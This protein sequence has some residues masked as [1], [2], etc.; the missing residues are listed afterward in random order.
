MENIFLTIFNMS[1]TASY[2][3]LAVILIRLLLKKAPKALRVIM[4]ALVGIRLIFPFSFESILSLIPSTETVPQNIIYSQSPTINSGIPTINNAINPVI[5]ESLAPKNDG[6]NS[7]QIWVLIAAI[8]W[9]I[10]IAAMVIYAAVSYFKIRFKI[11]E[12]AH[13]KENIYICDNV[14][15]PFILGIIKPKI[16][17]PSDMSAADLEYVTAHEKAHIKRLDHLWK[18]L[19]FLL[20]SVYWFNP[21]LWVAYILLCKDIELACDE[22][23]IRQMGAEIKKPYS[24][25]LLNCSVPKRL[26]SACPL[27]FGETGVK[28]RIK[29]VL[30]YKRPTFW[31]IAI[32]LI[33]CIILSI[34]FLT[35]PKSTTI[36]YIE[37]SDFSRQIDD[38]VSVLK[39]TDGSSFSS[40]TKVDKNLLKQLF[41]IEI[42]KNAV[43][44]DRSDYFYRDHTN[45][46]VLRETGDLTPSLSSSLQGFYICFNKDFTEVFVCGR[47]FKTTLSYRVKSPEKAKQ[48]FNKFSTDIKYYDWKSYDE[49]LGLPTD[50]GLEVYVWM[51]N[52]GLYK[53]VLKSGRNLGYTDDEIFSSKPAPL[54]T[55]RTI[56]SSYDIPQDRITII[57]KIHPDYNLKITEE[58]V[59]VIKF[60]LFGLASYNNIEYDDWG[61]KM[62]LYLLD[63]DYFQVA[64][65][66]SPEH[67]KVVGK[68][69][70]S[71]AF[72]LRAIHNGKV[73]SFGDYMRNVLNQKDYED[74]VLAWDCV[75]YTL[76]SGEIFTLTD[77]FKLT[78]GDLPVGEYLLCKEVRFEDANGNFTIRTYTA[79][80]AVVD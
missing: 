26:I 54:A 64:F 67:Q 29:S 43:S 66:R 77:S 35:N 65:E 63:D 30:N 70:T 75:L 25:A 18:P 20:L 6:S 49:Y 76:P 56:L 48:I 34:C 4:W 72:E 36:T 19:G 11:R 12:A 60:D 73:I 5:S 50:K 27:A 8:V 79:P 33:S 15:T 80:F 40:I 38:T 14:G 58:D 10:G 62:S 1:I 47:S 22:K 55:M 17:I 16:Y 42:S 78:Y 2:I 74:K 57:P 7:L 32:A 39:T 9:V 53:S 71:P 51:D 59:K 45:T 31:V 46:I 52:S 28:S 44:N 69:T 61:I 3:A 24:E 13:L 21:I 41:D 68:F 37:G 23:V